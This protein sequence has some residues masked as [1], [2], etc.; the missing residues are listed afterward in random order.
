MNREG[1]V[2]NCEHHAHKLLKF[3]GMINICE[4]LIK[5]LYQ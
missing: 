4:L 5:D 1:I 2:I 3:I